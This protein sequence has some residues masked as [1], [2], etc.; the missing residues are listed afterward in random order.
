MVAQLLI[1]ET[2]NQ[3]KSQQIKSNDSFWWEEKTGVPGEKPLR[4]EQSRVEQRTNINST[5][6]YM[7]AGQGIEPG[8]HCRVQLDNSKG[9]SYSRRAHVLFFIYMHDQWTTKLTYAKQSRLF[10]GEQASHLSKLTNQSTRE[11][12]FTCT[13]RASQKQHRP[14]EVPLFFTESGTIVPTHKKNLTEQRTNKFNICIE[15]SPAIKQGT[16]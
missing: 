3:T 1:E 9:N 7:T 5:H 10:G 2:T 15:L 4:T 14:A 12:V 6:G 11:L 16:Q 8:P 13:V